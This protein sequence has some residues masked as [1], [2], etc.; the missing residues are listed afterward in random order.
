[1]G[2]KRTKFDWTAE[3]GFAERVDRPTRQQRR[4]GSRE[5]EQLAVKLAEMPAATRHRLPLESHVHEA[6]DV[7]ASLARGPA[8]K[9]QRLRVTTLLMGADREALDEALAGGGADQER[10]WALERWRERLIA[11]GDPAVQAFVAEHPA[12]DRQQL[13]QLARKAA[14]EGDAAARARKKLFAVLKASG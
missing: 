3:D 2:R 12:A 10:L 4:S 14:G 6:L 13:R 7:L 5:L 1:M 8:L 11:E 9:R